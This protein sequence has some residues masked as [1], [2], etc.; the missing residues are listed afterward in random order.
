M[1]KWATSALSICKDYCART[2]RHVADGKGLDLGIE[3]DNQ[4]T[5][6]MILTDA[7]RLQQ[8]LKN[9][10]SNAL[11]FTE[12]G[13]VRLRIE[14]VTKGYSAAHPVL[15]RA[16]SVIAFSVTDTG[17]GIAQ[18]KQR[19]IFEA[20]QQA[21][22]TTSRK[23]GG[24]GLGLSI[25]RELARL[26]GGEIRLQSG[27]GRGS[28][29][30]LYLPQSYTSS[31][32][33]VEGPDTPALQKPA[34]SRP[35]SEVEVEELAIDDDRNLIMGG[36]RVLLI[37][38]DDV[39]F[40]RI[41]LDLAHDRGMKGDCRAARR[42]GHYAGPRV[43]A[44]RHHARRPPSRYER[45]DSARSAQ[46][47]SGDRAHACAPDLGPRKQSPRLRVGRH[48]LPAE[49]AHTGI[50]GRGVR[51]DSRFHAAS[52]KEAAADCRER[53]PRGGHQRA[54]RRGRP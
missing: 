37:V 13:S 20:F 15:N 50:A 11:K 47:R 22:G 26:L 9:L 16:R 10:L 19:I 12:Q 42:Y 27:L 25:S 39:T 3:V 54:A 49:R 8:V 14:R 35:M 33:K 28:I 6:D 17:I 34:E 43:S 4:L 38:E 24:T 46:A 36:E 30:T 41:M 5:A 18:E 31:A 45:L 32:P 53:R 40:A 2:F 21:D 48:E 1:S 52:A 7:K 44:E 29:F 23:Y 51:R